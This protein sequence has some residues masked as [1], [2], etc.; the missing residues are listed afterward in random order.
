MW[1]LSVV[2]LATTCG[3]D[4]VFFSLLQNKLVLTLTEDITIHSDAEKQYKNQFP[5][6]MFNNLSHFDSKI[7]NTSGFEVGFLQRVKF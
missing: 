1:Q 3:I 2:H 7:S 6:K 5:G 4:I